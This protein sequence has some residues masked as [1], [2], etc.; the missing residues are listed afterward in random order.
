MTG[1]I[2][3]NFLALV[4]H[5]TFFYNLLGGD[6]IYISKGKDFWRIDIN[7]A[8]SSKASKVSVA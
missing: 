6:I 4:D 7:K 3:N 2:M 1:Y 8:H 5:T